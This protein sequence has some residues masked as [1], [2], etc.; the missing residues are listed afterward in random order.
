MDTS[1]FR[2]RTIFKKRKNPSI[3]DLWI[4]GLDIGFSGVKIMSPNGIHCIPSYAKKLDKELLNISQANDSTILY[5]DDE[6]G[7]LWCV[8]AAAQNMVSPEDSNDSSAYLYGRNRYFSDMFKVIAR[9]GLAIGMTA[10][11]FGDPSGKK[12][13]VQTGLPPAYRKSDTPL[14]QEALSGAHKFRIKIGNRNWKI[15]DFTLSKEN[16]PVMAQPMGT[17][18]SII[19]DSNGKLISGAD[20]YLKSK[21]LIFDPGFNTFD[22]FDMLSFFL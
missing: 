13:I 2:T 8:G 15:Y 19:T 21:L 4:M 3:D 6:T 11:E 17:L 1:L 20:K 22:L 9:T 5:R 7:E 10:N 16:I 18:F 12:L 14:I